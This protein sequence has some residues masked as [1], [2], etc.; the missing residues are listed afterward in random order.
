MKNG[1][2]KIIV[3]LL[4]TIVVLALILVVILMNNHNSYE[5][6][7]KESN[8]DKLYDTLYGSIS[9][10]TLVD[11]KTVQAELDKYSD[12]VLES[13]N[14]DSVGIKRELYSGYLSNEKYTILVEYLE[15]G[16]LI[17]SEIDQ[18]VR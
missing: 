17:T 6:F 7:I 1:N 9:K 3:A 18:P 15:D 11:D 2:K 5:D 14:T 10:D 16:V 13:S 8:D 4:I 12:V